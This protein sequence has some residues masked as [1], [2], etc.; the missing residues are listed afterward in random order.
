MTDIRESTRHWL[1]RAREW[2]AQGERRIAQECILHA[3][4]RRRIKR[5][6]EAG[7]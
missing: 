1:T 5:M 6:L 3:W 4:R 7:A 2:R